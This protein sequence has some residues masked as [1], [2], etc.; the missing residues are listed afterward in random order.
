VTLALLA[1]A[2]GGAVIIDDPV[3]FLT[4]NSLPLVER[5]RL[6]LLVVAGGLVGVLGSLLVAL[7]RRGSAAAIVERTARRW[8]PAALLWAV[9]ALATRPV[10]HDHELVFLVLLSATVLLIE[11]SIRLSASTMSGHLAD[12]LAETYTR[13]PPRFRRFAPFA[14]VLISASTYAA[15]TGYWTIQ[16]HHRLATASFDLGILDNV[17]FNAMS[18][19]GFRAPVLFGPSGGS[20]L[21]GHAN[22]VLYLFLPFY[23]LFPRAETLLV[24]QSVLLGFAAVPLYGFAATKLPR[25]S[26]A[27]VS[28]AYLL[29]APMHGPNFYDFHFLPTSIFFI[30]SLFWAL[31]SRRTVLVWIIWLLCVSIREDIPIGLATLGLFMVITGYSVR[32]GLWMTLLSATAFVV[33][34]FVIM[35]MAGTWWFANIYKEL[36]PA[37]AKSYGGVVMTLLTNPT[38]AL[39]TLLKQSKLVYALHLLAPLVFLP[40]RRWVYLW[41]LFAGFFL[42]LMTTGYKYTLSIAFQY[43]AHWIPYLFGA[44][45]LALAAMGASRTGRI[46]R[47]AALVALVV[48]VVLHSW[49]FGAV[50]DPIK[51][52]G[53]FHSVPFGVTNSERARYQDLREV[54]AMIPPEASVVATDPETPHISNRVTA[55]A[56]RTGADNAE[57]FLIRRFSRR[58]AREKAQTALNDYDYG[59]LAKVGEFYLFKRGHESPETTQALR[60]LQLKP[61]PQNE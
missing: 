24:I 14:L 54:V 59:L 53:G 25:W 44:S 39:S 57:Y 26:A 36:M 49:S 10:W 20:L 41:L 50:L 32:T 3:T 4:K 12:R 45:V 2:V 23:W 33:I 19:H 31:A 46:H 17:M 55:H 38:F 6:V 8:S 47:Q 7:L 60:K 18:G 51:F 35:P 34:K 11:Q 16:Q 48:G 15:Y 61:G 30:F 58:S 43:T 27:L 22:F 52:V 40:L 9:L 56:F 42:T 29:Y 13:L 37:D 21:A 1:L 28:L 5:R